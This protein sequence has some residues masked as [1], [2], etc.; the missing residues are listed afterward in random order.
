MEEENIEGANKEFN[1][2]LTNLID[3]MS[4][5]N[6]EHEST[7]NVCYAEYFD[8]KV[9]EFEQIEKQIGLF[10]QSFSSNA[11]DSQEIKTAGDVNKE[12]E[13]LLFH[14][15]ESFD[16]TKVDGFGIDRHYKPIIESNNNNNQTTA[17]VQGSTKSTSDG[18]NFCD[19]ILKDID[20]CGK[21][22]I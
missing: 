7:L 17:A 2:E 5:A 18:D 9:K 15:R 20:N 19:F 10:I 4:G 6:F 16:S 12:R 21:S 13:E 3:S 11:K 1:D 22:G 14:I 8:H